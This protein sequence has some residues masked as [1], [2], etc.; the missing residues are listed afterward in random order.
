MD[1]ERGDAG[2]G[3]RR[4]PDL[5][6]EVGQRHQVV[7]DQGGRCREAVAGELYA[8][9][10]IA[11][12]ADDNPLLFLENLGQIAPEAPG[13]P[14]SIIRIGRGPARFERTTAELRAARGTASFNHAALGSSG[15]RGGTRV[16]SPTCEGRRARRR[17]LRRR[18]ARPQPG[19]RVLQRDGDLGAHGD[20]AGG[21]PPVGLSRLAGGGARR[22]AGE[23]LDGRAVLRGAGDHRGEHARGA[24]RRL[25]A[26]GAGGFPRLAGAGPGC[27]RPGDPRGRREHHHQRHD[28]RHQ[29]AG[30]QRDRLRRLRLRVAHLVARRHG[31]EP[32]GRPGDLGRG[33]PL[34]LQAGARAD[35]RGRGAGGGGARR[36][37]LRLLA[38]DGAHLHPVSARGLGGPAVL[39]AG[40]RRRGS[41][42]WPASPSR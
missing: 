38:R 33:H 11:R 42:W 13:I 18:E 39:A 4:R 25:P 30:R 34:A 29:P 19:L 36:H 17:L 14:R 15:W 1:L 31:R 41:C 3:P 24:R 37:R 12:E 16:G 9:A 21:G 20:L 26:A 27:D 28:R 22:P 32:G 7:A 2:Q 8:V 6:R 35:P 10:R 40:H 23:R 5:G